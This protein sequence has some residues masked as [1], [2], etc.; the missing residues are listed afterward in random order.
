MRLSLW[1]REPDSHQVSGWDERIACSAC[2]ET[3]LH[4]QHSSMSACPSAPHQIFWEENEGLCFLFEKKSNKKSWQGC[5]ARRTERRDTGPSLWK[6]MWKHILKPKMHIP[7]DLAIS[8]LGIH[9]QIYFHMCTKHN[10][11]GASHCSITF[12]RK[13]VEMMQVPNNGRLVKWIMI[14]LC[15]K[16]LHSL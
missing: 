8:V 14:Y 15:N 13:R 3:G 6:V 11:L 4:P 10:V 16:I 1:R 9:P 2:G 7:F 12:N 5:K